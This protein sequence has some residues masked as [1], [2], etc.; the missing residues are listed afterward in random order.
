MVTGRKSQLRAYFG[1]MILMGLYPK[2][3]RRDYWKRDPFVGYAPIAERYDIGRYLHF[4]DNTA[5]VPQGQPGYDRLGKVRE[6][7]EKVS[8]RFYKPHCENSVDEAMS[9]LKQ[10]MPAKPVKRGIKVWCRADAHNGYLC[11]FEV[12][13][14][15]SEGVQDSLGKRVVLGLSQ[16][17]EGLRYHL[18]FD[19]FFTSVSLLSSLLDKG[20][21]ACGTT[22][23]TYKEFP[24]ALRGKWSNMAS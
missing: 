7:M 20:L 24:V 8:N 1:I 15:R 16:K 9:S 5:L 18:Y 3:A 12:Y 14:G 11:Q 17:L 6:V 22:R 10:Y 2:P 4:A 21:Y 23:Q 13:T 19:N